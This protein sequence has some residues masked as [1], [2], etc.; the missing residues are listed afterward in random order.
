MSYNLLNSDWKYV[1]YYI[2]DQIVFLKNLQ[3][4][5]IYFPIGFQ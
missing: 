4:S 3:S 5:E 1:S 2:N